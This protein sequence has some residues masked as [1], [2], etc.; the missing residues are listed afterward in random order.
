MLN[1]KYILKQTSS[2]NFSCTNMT[3]TP[4]T[5]TLITLFHTLF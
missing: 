1:K 3:T 4:K 5:H 2:V